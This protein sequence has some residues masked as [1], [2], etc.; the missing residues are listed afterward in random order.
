MKINKFL[1]AVVLLLLSVPVGYAVLIVVF[2]ATGGIF[3]DCGVEEVERRK[4]QDGR[5][6]AMIYMHDCGATTRAT[7]RVSLASSDEPEKFEDVFGGDVRGPVQ[8]QWQG[9]SALSVKAGAAYRRDDSEIYLRQEEWNGV[10][11]LYVNMD[12]P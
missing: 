11:I 4:S 1:I 2:F 3:G 7:W 9:P 6:E 10:R 5:F 12:R 8:I